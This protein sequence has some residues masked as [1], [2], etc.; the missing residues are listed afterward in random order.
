MYRECINWT[1]TFYKLNRR[2]LQNII[3][4]LSSISAMSGFL[5]NSA[6]VSFYNVAL[7]TDFMIIISIRKINL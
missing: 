3:I 5:T 4:L 7:V 1:G 2:E 6:M